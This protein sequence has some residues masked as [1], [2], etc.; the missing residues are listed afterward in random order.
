MNAQ[1]A[2]NTEK[3]RKVKC[4]AVRNLARKSDVETAKVEEAKQSYQKYLSQ[5]FSKHR[6]HS[7]KLDKKCESVDF[8][9]PLCIPKNVRLNDSESVTKPVLANPINF[10]AAA[11]PKFS[12]SRLSSRNGFIE[13]ERNH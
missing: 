1:D 13:A 11:K 8:F 6:S 7:T 12:V 4:K 3:E 10:T 9:D 5:I 2:A